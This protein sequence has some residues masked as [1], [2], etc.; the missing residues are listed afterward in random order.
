[1]R[2][3]SAADGHELDERRLRAD[4]ARDNGGRIGPVLDRP[5]WE[6]VMGGLLRDG[7]AHRAGRIVRLGAA[8]IG[9]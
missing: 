9:A 5:G 6:R 2:L 3:L 8:T 1:M 4:L 7:L